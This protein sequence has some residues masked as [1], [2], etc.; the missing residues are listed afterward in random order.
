[1]LNAHNSGWSKKMLPHKLVSEIKIMMIDNQK[2]AVLSTWAST[3]CDMRYNELG[4]KT[5]KKLF[6]EM[7]WL[8]SCPLYILN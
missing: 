2:V 4:H 5:L 3:Y 1:M 8:A 7:P 6:S